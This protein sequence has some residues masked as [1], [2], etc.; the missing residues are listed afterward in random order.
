MVYPASYFSDPGGR[1]LLV[2]GSFD[3]TAR[4]WD[5]NTGKLVHKLVGHSTEVP[6]PPPHATAH[7]HTTATTPPPPHHQHI[8]LRK[9]V[10]VRCIPKLRV[11]V[12][13]SMDNTARVWDLQSGALL[14]TLSVRPA[15]NVN[16]NRNP[17]P[18]LNPNLSVRTVKQRFFVTFFGHSI[19]YI[20][21]SFGI[22]Y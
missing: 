14:H 2:T 10:S 6:T 17:K 4:V 19:L 21:Y 9:V 1:D 15:V 8:T 13:A 22:R 11:V 18:N 16:P 12:T 3:K 7:H 20:E 5:A